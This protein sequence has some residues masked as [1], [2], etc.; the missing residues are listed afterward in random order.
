M[1]KGKY[2]KD[3]AERKKKK[4][5][6]KK[7]H[8]GG[9]DKAPADAEPALNRQIESDATLQGAIKPPENHDWMETPIYKQFVLKMSEE[10]SLKDTEMVQ[11]MIKFIIEERRQQEKKE[12]LQNPPSPSPTKKSAKKKGKKHHKE[13]D[14]DEAHKGSGR[15]FDGDNKALLKEAVDRALENMLQENE[16]SYVI[17]I[18]K[19]KKDEN[20]GN[21]IL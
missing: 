21:D 1:F 3:E 8:H 12:N 5:K 18:L 10:E 19:D 20:A 6:T 16:I 13:D 7:K 9:Q 17:D 14:E 11:D 15:D 2:V 4:G